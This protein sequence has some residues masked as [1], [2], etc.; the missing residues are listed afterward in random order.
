MLASALTKIMQKL[1]ERRKKDKM[2][3]LLNMDISIPLQY[4]KHR[5]LGANIKLI[6]ADWIMWRL[7]CSIHRCTLAKSSLSTKQISSPK[8]RQIHFVFIADY[9]S[10]RCWAGIHFPISLLQY[11]SFNWPDK[12]ACILNDSSPAQSCRNHIYII[13]LLWFLM[14]CNAVNWHTQ[15]M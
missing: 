13:L 2:I 4:Y 1:Q 15:K 7:V 14:Q 10:C 12:V 8:T 6:Q 9:F 3:N 11:W 5:I